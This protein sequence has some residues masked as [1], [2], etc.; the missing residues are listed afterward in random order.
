MHL[1]SSPIRF[2][3]VLIAASAILAAQEPQPPAPVAPAPAAAP[4]P[5]APSPSAK[6]E[7]PNPDNAWSIS[8]LYW[9]THAN[10][11][12]SGGGQATAF[13]TV[14]PLGPSFN[15]PGVEGSF[16]LN[17]NDIL[18][19]S[20]FQTDGRGASIASQALSLYGTAYTAG[21]FLQN[22][23]RVRS[24]KVSFQDILYPFPNA[25]A[26]LRFRTLWEVQY[27]DVST[28]VDAPLDTSTVSSTGTFP[29]T[30]SS[31][32]VFL[33]TFGA[34]LHYDV[35]SHFSL[36]VKGSAFGIPHHAYIADSDA[37]ALYQIGPV[38]ILIG[39]KFLGFKTS[40]KSEEYVKG[41]MYGAIVGL[42]YTIR[43]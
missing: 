10:P 7:T 42:R 35:S 28:R 20:F 24:G 26:K 37:T 14:G 13:E 22:Q 8:L 19:L 5:A 39:G 29:S 15:S 30:E 33:P 9:L 2:F 17:K 16:P 31:H 11:R 4:G 18:Q 38:Q 34:S 12:L 21:D 36:E 23:Y 40:P 41:P 6:S 27:L 3:A 25:G 1:C 32:Q 43:E